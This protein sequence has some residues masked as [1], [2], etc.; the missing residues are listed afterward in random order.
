MNSMDLSSLGKCIFKYRYNILSI[1]R[2]RGS[3]RFQIKIPEPRGLQSG[4]QL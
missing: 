1:S 4:F 2:G 3:Y